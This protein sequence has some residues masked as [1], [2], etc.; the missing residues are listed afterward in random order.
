MHAGAHRATRGRLVIVAVA[1]ALVG[2]LAP[3]ASAK[4]TAKHRAAP[5]KPLPRT[6]LIVSACRFSHRSNDDPIVFPALAGVSHSHDFFGNVTTDASSTYASLEGRS[7]T[8]GVAGDTAAYWAPTLFVNGVAA[9]PAG[10]LAYYAVFGHQPVHTL[11][12]GLEMVAK[13]SASVRFSCFRHQMPTAAYVHMPTCKPGELMSVGVNFPSC[14][15][16]TDL[17][18]PDHRSHMAYASFGVCPAGY[19]VVVP[20]L[21]IWITY[22]AAPRGAQITLSSGGLDT[23]HADYVNAW[24]PH[25]LST[26]ERFC[27]A[28]HRECYKAMGRVLRN[29]RLAHNSLA[30][31]VSAPPAGS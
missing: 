14:W 31:T 29:L 26:L 30:A 23:A 16:G 6:G 24:D 15:N 10:M 2:A 8:C 13:G 5:R 22:K 28:G 1:V 17:D 4:V 3:A 9:R 25:T 21:A 19:P 7:T 27:L 12:M 18:S 11:P 20:R